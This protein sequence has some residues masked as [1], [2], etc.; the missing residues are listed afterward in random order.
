M[1]TI[2][3]HGCSR[4]S[5]FTPSS[6]ASVKLGFWRIRILPSGCPST[7]P[8]GTIRRGRDE[9]ERLSRTPK[10]WPIVAV[11]A[12]AGACS[13]FM[14]TSVVPIQAELP[15]LLGETR[16]AT[17]W[18]VTVTLL[19]ATVTTPIA[20]RLGDLYGK[21]R[22]V[23]A[24][25]VVLIVGSV[26]AALSQSLAVLLVGRALQGAMVGVVPLGIAILRD[27]LHERHI[28]GAGRFASA[29]LGFGGALGL[30][31]SALIAAS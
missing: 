22:I 28:G 15:E 5:R 31:V 25:I 21:R 23:L 2:V 29:T 7:L 27:H 10:T 14:F 20:G 4:I 12:F 1:L 24:L 6:L 30:P 13:S 17:A 11:L 9:R 18:V 8:S 26:I 3:I 16:E 19:T